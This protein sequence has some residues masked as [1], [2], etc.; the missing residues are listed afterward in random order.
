MGETATTVSDRD[1]VITAKN[2]IR[3]YVNRSYTLE[4]EGWITYEDIKVVYC[5]WTPK[6]WT[7]LMRVDQLIDQHYQ[8]SYIADKDEIRVDAYVL[9]DSEVAETSWRDL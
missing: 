7:V 6:N 8:V 5:V 2:T 9:A 4:A 3:E 1:Y